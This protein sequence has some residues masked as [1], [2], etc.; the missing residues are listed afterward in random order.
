CPCPQH[1]TQPPRVAFPTRR[2]SDLSTAAT[3][4]STSTGRAKRNP[5]RLRGVSGSS[6]AQVTAPGGHRLVRLTLPLA[7][8]GAALP[9]I[10]STIHAIS[11]RWIPYGDQAVIASQAYDVFTSHTPLLGQYS[12]SYHL[13]SQPTYSLGPMLYWLLAL[14]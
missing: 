1:V 3:G 5:H 14:P 11:E 10:V 12:A 7:C 6:E 8:L 9:V 2:S 4:T 13:V